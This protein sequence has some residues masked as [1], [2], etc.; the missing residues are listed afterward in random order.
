MLYDQLQAQTVARTS[1]PSAANS[2]MLA[3]V[4]TYAAVL[5]LLLKAQA[6]VRFSNTRVASSKSHARRTACGPAPLQ[7]VK[8]QSLAGPSSLWPPR[9]SSL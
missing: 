9:C 6:L 3:M 1:I 8:V 2:R 4:T 5:L 7:M